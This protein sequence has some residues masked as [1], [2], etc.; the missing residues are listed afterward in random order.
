MTWIDSIRKILPSTLLLGGD[1]DAPLNGPITD[2]EDRT[3][4]LRALPNETVVTA[5]D[6]AHALPSTDDC[7]WV[8]LVAIPGGG[9]GSHAEFCEIADVV[10]ERQPANV[11][12]FRA[13]R[14]A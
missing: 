11:N 12:N 14:T 7:T 4:Y 8:E 1:N 3:N 9:G 10:A 13:G 5:S 2:L 6:A